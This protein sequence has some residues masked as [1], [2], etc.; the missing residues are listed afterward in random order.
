MDK[1]TAEQFHH[2]TGTLINHM[3][4]I[5]SAA[6]LRMAIELLEN[7]QQ[8]EGLLLKEQFHIAY[9]SIKPLNIIKNTLKEA[10]KA[11]ELKNNILGATVGLSAG[12]VSKKLFQ[13][14]SGGPLKKILGTALQFSITNAVAKN[15]EMIKSAGSSIIKFFMH[16][17]K[18]KA[19]KRLNGDVTRDFY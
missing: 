2:Y 1:K 3:H 17:Y 5:K 12:Y 16:R 9:E 7:Q 15:P 11:P 18:D 10:S 13:F 8:Q 14:F 4:N 19:I 6:D